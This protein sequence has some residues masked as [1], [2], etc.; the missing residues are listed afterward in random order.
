MIL[1]I[2]HDFFHYE[3]G[4]LCRLFFPYEELKTTSDLMD[5]ENCD[6]AI[7]AIIEEDK[8]TVTVTNKEKSLTKVI[9]KNYSESLEYNIT[10]TMYLCMSEF[11][12]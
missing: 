6:F 7:K 4:N 9:A 5:T 12:N 2:S 8:S 1:Y 11:C 10:S 3:A